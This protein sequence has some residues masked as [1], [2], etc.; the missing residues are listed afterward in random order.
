MHNPVSLKYLR[1]QLV[2][3]II[4]LSIF[5]FVTRPFISSANTQLYHDRY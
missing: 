5:S 4:V 2:Y 1:H 3:K